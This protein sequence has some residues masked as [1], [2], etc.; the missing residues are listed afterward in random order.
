MG[1]LPKMV[2]LDN[3]DGKVENLVKMGKLENFD[4]KWGNCQKWEN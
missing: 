4:G 2:K 3:L 1:K